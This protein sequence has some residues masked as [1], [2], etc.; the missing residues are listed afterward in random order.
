MNV[1]KIKRRN[2]KMSMNIFLIK[3]V[4]SSQDN[5]YTTTEDFTSSVLSSYGAAYAEWSYTNP[6]SVTLTAY[7]YAWTIDKDYNTYKLNNNAQ[8]E[9]RD[10]NGNLIATFGDCNQIDWTT[11][12]TTG[13]TY[14][15]DTLY[16]NYMTLTSTDDIAVIMSWTTATGTQADPTNAIYVNR[17]D[18]YDKTTFALKQSFYIQGTVK[19]FI[20]NEDYIYF[21]TTSTLSTDLSCVLG[22]L[23]KLNRTTSEQTILLYPAMWKTSY[24]I[25]RICSFDFFGGDLYILANTSS[26]G[27]TVKLIK[28]NPTTAEYVSTVAT[29]SG[30]FNSKASKLLFD[31]TGKV[32][33]TNLN[34]NSSGSGESTIRRATIS[35]DF[36]TSQIIDPTIKV[37]KPKI[38]FLIYFPDTSNS[39]STFYYKWYKD[40][41]YPDGTSVDLGNI[42]ETYSILANSNISKFIGETTSNGKIY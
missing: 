5:I 8:I 40:S 37:Y 7:S 35:S 4:G 36:L 1:K 14:K 3:Y 29:L 24:G 6:N 16:V 33:I 25:N 15:V 9:K 32:Y 27:G 23:W 26:N 10:K 39:N 38:M 2:K 41:Y 17:I 12:N 19:D 22:T 13:Q 18:I 21:I 11:S 28:A 30:D 31:N 20:C 34:T 42:Q